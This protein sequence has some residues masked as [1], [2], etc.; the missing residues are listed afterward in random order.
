MSKL[1]TKDTDLD[2]V[3]SGGEEEDDGEE[4]DDDAEES[5]VS[6]TDDVDEPG[7]AP[8]EEEDCEEDDEVKT[9]A[10]EDDAEEEEDDEEEEDA[11]DEEE[12]PP[13]SV[14]CDTM[15]EEDDGD[16]HSSIMDEEEEEEEDDGDLFEDQEDIHHRT[17][18]H[19][20]R[21]KIIED[22]HPLLLKK[23]FDE[24]LLLSTVVRD[25]QGNIMDPYHKTYPF[26]T[27]Y[28]K[29]RVIGERAQELAC[30]AP[31]LVDIP[32]AELATL[33][34]FE[35][36]LLELTAKKIPYIIKRPLPS[37]SCE[38]WHVYDLEQ[39]HL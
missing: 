35:I 34:D 25:P 32:S 33:D 29:A 10:A 24:I 3:S 39:Y 21:E 37:G 8:P 12:D 16:D 9:V 38:Y 31:L 26:L 5:G 36:A 19:A 6:D 22:F 4:D 7:N 1:A 20:L 18:Q 2:S 13:E 30:G 28:E 14:A 23:D 11:E 27:K 17:L 15:E